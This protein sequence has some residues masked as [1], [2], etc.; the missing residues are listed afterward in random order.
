MSIPVRRAAPA[1]GA[2][3]ALFFGCTQDFEQF[4][5]SGVT[6]STGIGP[7]TSSVGPGGAG[8]DATVAS[9][10]AVTVGPGGTGGTGGGGTGGT[11][12]TPLENCLDGID[13]NNDGD[14]D[15]ADKDCNPDF[16]CTEPAP[17]GW[18]GYFRVNQQPYQNMMPSMCPDGMAPSTYFD[19]PT[20]AECSPCGCGNVMDAEC[21]PPPIECVN[22]NMCNNPSMI[23]LMGLMTDGTCFNVPDGEIGG[24]PERRCRLTSNTAMVV[25]QGTCPPTGGMLMNPDPWENQDDVCGQPIPGGGGCNGKDVCIPKGTGDYN[26]PVCIRKMGDDQCPG[27]FPNRIEAAT[28]IAD[29]RDCNA[30]TCEAA[31][32]TTCMGGGYTIF[33][34]DGCNDNDPK[35]TINNMM[36]TSVTQL[37]DN[38]T[39]SIEANPPQPM[40]GSCMADGGE[41]TGSATPMGEMV[42]FCC[43]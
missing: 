18:E 39:G 8:G 2:L 42:T 6:S 25:S 43:K 36:C 26:G 11:G 24:Q 38:T 9:S 35:V 5:P 30:C 21:A 1:L 27:D 16:E 33:E 3:I 15:C 20:M 17:T 14:I 10:S 19:T 13:N 40:G 4:E 28:E 41:P 12:G 32:G 31:T 7:S 34:E 22:S 23:N 29:D 37:L